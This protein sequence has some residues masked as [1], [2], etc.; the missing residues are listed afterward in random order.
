MCVSAVKTGCTVQEQEEFIIPFTVEKEKICGENLDV[1][2]IYT[3]PTHPIGIGRTLTN[4]FVFLQ[5]QRR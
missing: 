1:T 3:S 2:A 5:E 4:Y